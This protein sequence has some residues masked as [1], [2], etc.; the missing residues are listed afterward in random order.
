MF[1]NRQGLES[2]Y[3]CCSRW[4]S[5]FYRSTWAVLWYIWVFVEVRERWRRWSYGKWCLWDQ[6]PLVSPL[7]HI[8]PY[9]SI[10]TLIQIHR[11]VYRIWKTFLCLEQEEKCLKEGQTVCTEVTPCCSGLTCKGFMCINKDDAGNEKQSFTTIPFSF[12]IYTLN[13]ILTP[14]LCFKFF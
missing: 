13:G 12:S 8:I 2:A 9:Y 5:V 3:F 11:L 1:W 10:P 4:R 7:Y 6:K 14:S